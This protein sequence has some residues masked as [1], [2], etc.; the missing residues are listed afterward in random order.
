MQDIKKSNEENKLKRNSGCFKTNRIRL[1]LFSFEE[2]EIKEKQK[3]ENDHFSFSFK[4]N[5]DKKEAKKVELKKVQSK[6]ITKHISLDSKKTTNNSFSSEMDD[7]DS[8]SEE[9]S[10]MSCDEEE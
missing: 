4:I 9:S 1:E 10:K 3:Q 7:S 2:N 8:E 6:F 5:D